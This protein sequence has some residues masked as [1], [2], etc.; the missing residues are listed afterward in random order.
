M[1]ERE[2]VGSVVEGLLGWVGWLLR[3]VYERLLEVL[4]LKEVH[5][6]MELGDFK[7][8]INVLETE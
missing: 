1:E 4:D 2:R 6:A 3:A 7:L 8:I 5:E